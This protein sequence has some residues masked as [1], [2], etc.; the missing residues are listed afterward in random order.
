MLSHVV[1]DDG[2]LSAEPI[3]GPQSLEDP[4]GGVA[5]FPGTPEVICQDLVDDGGKGSGLGRRGGVWR[6]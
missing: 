3:L 6:R 1:L 5:L 4:M 2:V